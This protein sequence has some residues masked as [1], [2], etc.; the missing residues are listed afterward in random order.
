MQST[1]A[2]DLA[3]LRKALTASAREGGVALVPTMGALHVGHGSLIELARKHA[4]TVV[5]SLFV[6]PTQFGPNEDFA[7]YPR[8]LESDIAMAKDAGA[9]IIYTP[10]VEDIYPAGFASN[11]SAGP[12]STVLEGMSRPGHFDGVATVVAKLLLRVMPDVA[13]FGE[14]DYQQLCVIRRVVADLDIPVDIIGAPTLREADGLALS[15][16]NA[17]LSKEE[18]AVAPKIYEVLNDIAARIK[19][20]NV[21]ATLDLGKQ[22]LATTGFVPDYMALCNG[23]SLELLDATLPGARL[24]VAAKLGKTRLIDNIAVE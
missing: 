19:L 24:L 13:I 12:L 23:T 16:R 14:K 8:M 18:R 2:Q 4:K 20:G 7:K 1:V 6:N 15:S 11:L 5:V 21:S 10:T 9:T 22:M 17:Y 3:G